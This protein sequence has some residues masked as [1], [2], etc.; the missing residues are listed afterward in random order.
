[1]PSAAAT[2]LP[3][4]RARGNRRLSAKEKP[5]PESGKGFPHE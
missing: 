4:K 2:T 5:L 1:M 3:L